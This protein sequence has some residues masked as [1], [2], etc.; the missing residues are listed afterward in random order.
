[1]DTKQHRTPQQKALAAFLEDWNTEAD[2][3]PSEEEIDAMVEL[4][5]LQDTSSEQQDLRATFTELAERWNLET[6]FSSS[7]TEICEHE[8]YQKII[9]L[10]LGVL[11]LIFEYMQKGMYHHMGWALAVITGISN[12]DNPAKDTDTLKAASAAWIQWGQENGFIATPD[13]Q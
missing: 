2:G 11:P 9:E 13:P 12:E 10:G 5:N 4:Y 1:M 3:P 6:M 8:A 7:T